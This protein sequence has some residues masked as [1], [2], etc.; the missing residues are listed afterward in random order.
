[1]R[2]GQP[3]PSPAAMTNHVS[4]TRMPRFSSSVTAGTVGALVEVGT[5]CKGLERRPWQAARRSLEAQRNRVAVARREL[6]SARC[7]ND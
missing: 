2:D 7:G 6:C 3:T 5:V 1:M 4:V